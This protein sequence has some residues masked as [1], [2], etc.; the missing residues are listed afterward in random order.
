MLE[1]DNDKLRLTAAAAARSQAAAVRTST[2]TSS[3][4]QVSLSRVFFYA[5]TRHISSLNFYSRPDKLLAL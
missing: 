5:Q 2:S 1:V 3:P 4:A